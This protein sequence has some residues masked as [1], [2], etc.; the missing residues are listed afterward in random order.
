VRS[1]VAFCL[2]LRVVGQ[3]V[4]VFQVRGYFVAVGAGSHRAG[5]APACVEGATDPVLLLTPAATLHRRCA[6]KQQSE[7][8]AKAGLKARL[9]NEA[10]ATWLNSILNRK[11]LVMLACAHTRTRTRGCTR[12]RPVLAGTCSQGCAW[13]WAPS[14]C[15]GWGI[16]RSARRAVGGGGRSRSSYGGPE[17]VCLQYATRRV[18]CCAACRVLC[19]IRI[20]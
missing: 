17:R 5:H 9:H 12:T 6:Q 3:A 10:P 13:A 2:M 1:S 7:A 19:C 16:S 15:G 4:G 8:K 11:N 14:R 18:A 20:I